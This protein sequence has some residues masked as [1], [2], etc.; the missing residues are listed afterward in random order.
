MKPKNLD[1]LATFIAERDGINLDVAR[2]RIRGAV[3]SMEWAFM[4][5]SY[6]GAEA[7][8]RGALNLDPD[9]LDLFIF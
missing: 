7:V 4:N 5:G 9:Y 3:E 8:L 2:A 6:D 1:E